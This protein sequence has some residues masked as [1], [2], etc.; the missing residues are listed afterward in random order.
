MKV[1]IDPRSKLLHALLSGFIFFSKQTWIDITIYIL[2]IAAIMLLFSLKKD[3]M[4]Y[5]I[6]LT[7]ILGIQFLYERFPSSGVLAAVSIVFLILMRMLPFMMMGTILI[8]TIQVTDLIGAMNMMR[9]P[10]T[11]I[12]PFAVTLRFMPTIKKEIGYIKDA[13]ALRNISLIG[14][15]PI[16]SVEYL[17]VPL[18]FRTTKVADELSASA[19]TRCIDLDVKK[20]SFTKLKMNILDYVYMS[21][22]VFVTAFVVIH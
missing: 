15:H 11:V 1:S 5:G 20:T 6:L 18:L 19:E 16:K 10:R 2:F 17:L 7:I 8:K 12:I 9:I 21:L 4:N 22:A 13:M 3:L 14:F